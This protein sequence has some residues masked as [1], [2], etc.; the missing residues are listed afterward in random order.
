M[1]ML[2]PSIVSV[3]WM[4]VSVEMMRVT[5]MAMRKVCKIVT[6]PSDEVLM[7]IDSLE[8]RK[9]LLSIKWVW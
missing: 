5:V 3:A 4:D 2:P 6:G 1:A 7:A 8:R 9:S